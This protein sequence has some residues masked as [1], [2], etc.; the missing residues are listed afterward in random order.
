MARIEKRGYD[1]QTLNTL[2]RDVQALGEGVTLEVSV[3][4]PETAESVPQPA[5]GR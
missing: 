1:A 2:R 5:L 4:Q 3:R